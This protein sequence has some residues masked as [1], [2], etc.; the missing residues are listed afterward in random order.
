M[1]TKNEPSSLEA[2]NKEFTHSLSRALNI[3]W[4]FIF[5]GQV[6]RHFKNSAGDLI[7]PQFFRH[8][9]SNIFDGAVFAGV[10]DEIQMGA[11][12]IRNSKNGVLKPAES[13]PILSASFALIAGVGFETATPLLN[14]T[15]NFDVTD[16]CMHAASAGAYAV[17]GV[18][19]KRKFE[20]KIK[21]LELEK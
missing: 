14:P 17:F 6:C 3:G 15:R 8:H 13:H 10:I 2:A 1:S 21:A 5:L 18:R 20:A 12:L 16:T 9:L 19:R 7:V 4:A 11:Q